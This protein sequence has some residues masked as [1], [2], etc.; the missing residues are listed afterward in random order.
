MNE[1]TT[2][3]VG[4]PAV[5]DGADVHRSW[6]QVLTG[7]DES[8]EGAKAVQG[9]E[10]GHGAVVETA[11]GALLLV[12]DEHI[13]GWGE[14]Y[15][16]GKAYPLLD[17]AVMLYLV[18]ADGALKALWARHFQTAKGAFGAAGRGQLRKHLA[19]RPPAPGLQVSVVDAG[20]GRP[21]VKP[22]PC[23]WCET[24]LRKDQGVLV[25][26]GQD[27]QVEH[28]GECPT[29]LAKPGTY[30]AVCGGSV[31][32]GT[33]R[34]VVV[35]EGE[36]RR[37]VRHTGSCAEHLSFEEHEERAARR[38]AD[39]EELRAAEKAAEA[40]KAQRR[41]AAAEKRRA[42]R[43][44]KE[45]AERE[46]AEAMRA[47]VE[48][49]S[50]VEETGRQELFNKKLNPYGERMR[51]VEVS[52]ILTDGEPARWW[53]VDAYGVDAEDDDRGGRYFLPADAR[54]EYQRYSYEEER[55]RPARRPRTGP[56]PCPPGGAKHCDNCGT[57]V[58]VGG[59]MVA[60]LGRACGADCYDAMADGYGAH[61]TRYHG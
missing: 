54:S 29:E 38:R 7:L 28:R 39:E 10:V 36:G 58:A 21:N 1:Q 13:T 26:R 49:L 33:A 43:E 34:I 60:S 47:R 18:Q 53:D 16:T 17:A 27:A 46:E 22:G 51:L 24:V 56:V 25:G 2:V 15:R 23:R 8:A 55:Y 37:E 50:V 35:R 30:C 3:R 6:R 12:V 41:A 48:S 20:P 59:W 14:A 32:P 42:A 4:V 5:P 52:A 40:K 9:P 31:A 45:K 61:A 11:P 19:A 57:T 44:A